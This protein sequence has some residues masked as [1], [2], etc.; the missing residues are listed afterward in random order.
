MSPSASPAQ[1]AHCS[2]TA[3][4][5]SPPEQTHRAAQFAAPTP[6]PLALEVFLLAW[7]WFVP[8]AGSLS[9]VRCCSGSWEVAA[10]AAAVV[11]LMV[12]FRFATCNS[13]K[14]RTKEFPKV[15]SLF[16]EGFWVLLSLFCF[17]FKAS[18]TVRS[19]KL[20]SHTRAKSCPDPRT[21][22]KRQGASGLFFRH[23]PL[24]ALGWG[25][26]NT[27]PEQRL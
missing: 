2:R 24:G 14:A 25:K 17:F 27:F 23:S 5:S 22:G 7:R 10:A 6:H 12:F 18:P 15:F 4:L 8:G 20:R 21:A 1:G 26:G 16:G 13:R 11:T 3:P 9:S 19:R